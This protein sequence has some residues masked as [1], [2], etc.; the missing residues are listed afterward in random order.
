MA[1]FC[2]SP[3]ESK[4]DA[5]TITADLFSSGIKTFPEQVKYFVVNDMADALVALV[6]YLKE[7]Y[8]TI[9]NRFTLRPDQKAELTNAAKVTNFDIP[10]FVKSIK[11][12]ERRR[13]KVAE[14]AQRR[15]AKESDTAI[16][17]ESKLEFSG[18]ALPEG[19]NI[20][21]SLRYAHTGSLRNEAGYVKAEDYPIIDGNQKY[22]INTMVDAFSR[23]KQGFILA[24]GPGVGKTM[25]LLITAQEI[26]RRSDKPVLIV[27]PNTQIR[28]TRF[29]SDMELI[30]RTA[31]DAIRPTDTPQKGRVTIVTY[32]DVRSGRLS[33]ME[34]AAVLFDESQVLASET[35]A[36]SEMG[37]E[38]KADFMVFASGTPFDNTN[39]IAFFLSK[40]LGMPK[41]DIEQDLGYWIEEKM[42][43]NTKTAILHIDKKFNNDRYIFFQHLIDRLNALVPQAIKDGTM[44]HRFY[45]FFGSVSSYDI[46]PLLEDNA[47]VNVWEYWTKDIKNYINATKNDKTIT[48]ATRNSVLQKKGQQR[49]VNTSLATEASKKKAVYQMVKNDLKDGNKV[50]IA[51]ENIGEGI[52]NDVEIEGMEGAMGVAKA[53]KAKAEQKLEKRPRE[54]QRVQT[55]YGYMKKRLQDDGVIFTELNGSL[56][57]VQ[58]QKAIQEFQQGNAMVMLMTEKS[59]GVGVDLDDQTGDFPRVMYLMT[60]PY[61]AKEYEQILYR[62]SRKNTKT[63][64]TVKI[65]K[66]SNSK[67]DQRRDLLSAAR[68][69]I[70]DASLNQKDVGTLTG[71]F[72][73]FSRTA[74]TAEDEMLAS[75][76][77]AENQDMLKRKKINS[78]D[79]LLKDYNR[80]MS[81]FT[82]GDVDIESYFADLKKC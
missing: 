17:P 62:V 53:S 27:V 78:Y 60:T 73:K 44:L 43:G 54:K 10:S 31:L 50:V 21:P 79:E 26:S 42:V 30:N 36:Q 76:F 71:G 33:S 69:S 15:M 38:L 61:S 56:T 74:D 63:P 9:P 4:Q 32:S 19:P 3:Q 24:D 2:P 8:N 25:Q 70:L 28:D 67:S 14:Q 34:F 39:G 65:I 16:R 58:K 48:E 35:S 6:P 64:A 46:E 23:G 49:L 7:A 40:A 22:G 68:K 13:Q 41:E 66:I 82:T 37:R 75:I 57:D 80:Y 18:A 47:P 81:T 59:G 29:K 51:T 1:D 45:P 11:D 12:A 20:R 77:Y 5:E 72:A 55:A 52:D